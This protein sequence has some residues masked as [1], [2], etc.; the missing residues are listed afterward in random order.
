MKKLVLSVCTIF[1]CVQIALAQPTPSPATDRRLGAQQRAAMAEK[2]L[3]KGLEF[4]NIGP[5]IFSGRVVDIEVDPQAPH[6]FYVAYA[7]GGL[8]KTEN[9]GSTFTP[10]FDQ[11][12]VITIGDIAVHWE[13]EIIWVGTGESNSSRSSY[14]GDGIYQSRDD[15]QSWQYLGLPESHHIGRI[16]LHPQDPDLAWVAALGHLYSANSERGIY[17]TDDGGKTWDLTLQVNENTGGVDLVH[18][19]DDP[20]VLFAAMWERTRRA[21]DFT[22]AGPGSVKSQALRVRSHIAAKR[23]SGSSG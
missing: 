3:F 11:Q 22:E 1:A 23:T 18:H 5:T 2:S 20:E 9:N 6:I 10:I 16:I 8:W 17:R 15:G 13:E 4:K 7:S 14:A 19:P 21:W 12:S